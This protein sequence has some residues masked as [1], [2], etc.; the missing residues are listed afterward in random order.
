M[1]KDSAKKKEQHHNMG[2]SSELNVDMESLDLSQEIVTPALE[3]GGDKD[4]KRR[5]ALSK[6]KKI[7]KKK[8]LKFEEETP[9]AVPVD[10]RNMAGRTRGS[11]LER[12]GAVDEHPDHPSSSLQK[13]GSTAYSDRILSHQNSRR[14]N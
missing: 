5:S 12:V 14:R 8:D 10:T 11:L 3:S 1:Y 7:H 6:L 13:G 9:D 4:K 2:S